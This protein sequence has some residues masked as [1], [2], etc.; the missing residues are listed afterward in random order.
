[1]PS[2]AAARASDSLEAEDTDRLR[3][4]LALLLAV[5]LPTAASAARRVD[6]WE[7]LRQPVKPFVVKDLD[8]HPLRLAD[9]TGKIVVL[10]FWATWCRPCVEELPELAQ[11][12]RRLAAQP[13]VVL[14]S[15]NIGEKR[16]DVEAFLKT[17]PV[18]FPVYVGDSLV[19]PLE[20]GAFPTKVILD[21][22]QPGPAGRVLLRYRR[23][24]LTSVASIEAR[25]QELLA[26]S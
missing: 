25:V 5:S 2:R 7:V 12:H 17:S 4:T 3:A 15:L 19:G 20:L 13:Q 16:E 14:L 6:G 9:L 26:E 21:A 8:G 24:G 1:M 11:Y 10:D 23:E 18:D 22:R